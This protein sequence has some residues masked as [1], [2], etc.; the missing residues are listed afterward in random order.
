MVDISVLAKSNMGRREYLKF[1][2]TWYHKYRW[3]HQILWTRFVGFAVETAGS[4]AVLPSVIERTPE[5]SRGELAGCSDL[6]I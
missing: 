2:M 3:I 4:T 6:G 1:E 5:S